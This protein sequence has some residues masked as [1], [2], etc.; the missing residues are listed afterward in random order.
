M[1]GRRFAILLALVACAG[2]IGRQHPEL[3]PVGRVGQ[4]VIAPFGTIDTTSRCY[5]LAFASS[6]AAGILPQLVVLDTA[7][8]PPG[9]LRE[10]L[11]GR[12][13]RALV[14]SGADSVWVTPRGWQWGSSADG[15]LGLAMNGGFGGCSLRLT[16]EP[17]AR[18]LRGE[19][20]YWSDDLGRKR[21]PTRAVAVAFPCTALLAGRARGPDA[22]GAASASAL[23]ERLLDD[24][25]RP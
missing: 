4:R 13:V 9:V 5:V 17:G 2:G 1:L 15:T 23:A 6:L 16:P 8:P 3:G 22:A 20:S 7:A 18:S 11:P 19:V 14:V 10:T 25:S 24:A 21:A 12:R